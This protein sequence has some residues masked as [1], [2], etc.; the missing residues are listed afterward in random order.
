MKVLAR[1]D[2]KNLICEVNANEL[3]KVFNKCAYYININDLSKVVD[4]DLCPGSEIDL[5]KGY[6]FRDDIVEAC[7]SMMKAY[8]KFTAASETLIKF[9]E[10]VS[11]ASKETKEK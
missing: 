9:A 1:A 3:G 2:S 7:K 6:D 4:S 11:R 5:G 8:E 10:M